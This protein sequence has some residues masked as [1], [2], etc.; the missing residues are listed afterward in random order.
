MA[1]GLQKATLE[2][3]YKKT[4]TVTESKPTEILTDCEGN[5]PQLQNP[6]SVSWGFEQTFVGEWLLESRVVSRIK[7]RGQG[8]QMPLKRRA[9]WFR[10]A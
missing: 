8:I 10:T 3:E 5:M 1:N 6:V 9:R 2:Y 7:T 4:A